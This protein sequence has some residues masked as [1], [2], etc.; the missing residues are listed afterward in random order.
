MPTSSEAGQGCSA[1]AGVFGAGAASRLLPPILAAILVLLAG[2]ASAQPRH[3]FSIYS[4][5]ARPAGFSHFS[6]VEP[7]APKGGTFRQGTTVTFN[8]TNRLRFPGKAPNELTYVYDTLMVRALDEPASFY[9][10]LAES[11]DVASDFTTA[12]FVL[13]PEARWHDGSRVT[14]EDIVFTF[15][16]LRD[17]GLPL[18]RSTL[19][20]VSLTALS[21]C[22]VVIETSTPGDWRPL[23]LVSTFPIHPKHHWASEPLDRLSAK[24]PLG[25]GP[26]RVVSLDANNA[27]VLDAVPDY[28]ARDLPVNRG[29]WNFDRIET[30]YFRDQTAM[31]E[32]V[33]AGVLD[34]HREI[35]ASAWHGLYSGPAF[36]RGDLV[37]STFPD[38]R[39]GRLTALTFNL[40]NPPLDDRRVRE[41][42]TL[43]FDG[44]WT[45]ETL[46]HGLYGP[47]GNLYGP[48]DLAASGAAG[49]GERALL[50]P[51]LDDLP[52]G[53]L[54]APG[55]TEIDSLTR[56]DRLR[57]ADRL[58]RDAGLVVVDGQRVDPSSGD[59]LSLRFVGTRRSVDR[60][61]APYAASLGRLG[62]E[63]EMV[64]YDYI[65]G[66]DVILSHDFDLTITTFHSG[67]PPGR[68]E[69]IYWHSE[70]ARE[71]GYALAG[72][73]DPALD[74]TIE[75]MNESTD[76]ASILDASRAFERIMQWQ[77]Y[78]LPLWRNEQN[79]FV[80][81]KETRFPERFVASGFHY[82]PYIYRKQD[83]Q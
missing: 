46:F 15:E 69:R 57:R 40:R 17:H 33:N 63:L 49:A 3:G 74:A 43:A 61:L 51:F 66:R 1:I 78:L 36:D 75:A 18:Y 31:I 26:Y 54:E 23:E 5:L 9:G 10:L 55:P 52:G 64:I 21:D 59:Q 38:P 13:R 12:K 34:A 6:Y 71:P 80:H 39:G 72:A 70:R 24:I 7:D 58:L 28:W 41:A 67:F 8:T 48:T 50:Q 82:F 83:L 44:A 53:I 56:R 20:T 16:T 60:V 2:V 35:D 37:R 76:E 29:L 68:D 62:I 14:S 42:L 30:L 45:R 11:V 79:W 81:K 47:P 77:T 32:A 22:I 65:V 19:E 27:V 73:E 25:S 4:D